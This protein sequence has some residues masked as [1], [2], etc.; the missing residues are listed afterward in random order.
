M[1]YISAICFFL[2]CWIPSFS[3]AQIPQIT[4]DAAI[5]MNANTHEILFSK[6]SQK[7]EYPASMTKVM[8]CMLALENKHLNRIVEISPNAADV[9][10]TRVNPGDQVRMV[11]LLK[12]MM[13][14]SDNG[15]ATA[16]GESL[17]QGDIAY[18]SQQMNDKAVSLGM[19][20]THFTNANGMPDRNHYSTAYDMALLMSYALKN[21]SFRQIIERKEA[22]IYYVYPVNR[23]ES[24]TSTNELLS[25]Y[26][27]IIGGKT[28]WT[29]AA[30][31]CF[32]AGAERDGKT[33]V[34]VVM[35]SQDDET[36]FAEARQLLDY[37]FS[38]KAKS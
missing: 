25:D 28:G 11:D 5:V 3:F 24:F 19:N 23:V 32:V 7:R 9:E 2:I 22:S 35:H 13:M 8:T 21:K 12:Q 26:Q 17:A 6:N 18:F 36:R 1:R 15:A 31:G 20:N 34:V 38:Q 4:A 10:C 14:V 29:Q 30:Q 37:G 33:L 16:I 27:G